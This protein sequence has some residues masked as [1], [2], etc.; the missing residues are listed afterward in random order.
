MQMAYFNEMIS[1]NVW[2]KYFV[3]IVSTFQIPHKK[4]HLY[5]KNWIFYREIIILEL[6]D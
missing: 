2:L 4:S 6:L 1:F 3:W 5:I